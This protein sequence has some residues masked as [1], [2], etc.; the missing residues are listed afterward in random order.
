MDYPIKGV[1]SGNDALSL[2]IIGLDPTIHT[3]L[4]AILVIASFDPTIHRLLVIVMQQIH[5]KHL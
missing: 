2:V 1:G 4:H 5:A 3:L